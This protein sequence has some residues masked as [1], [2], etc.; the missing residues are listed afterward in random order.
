MVRFSV[1]SRT[2]FSGGTI[3]VEDSDG[4]QVDPGNVSNQDNVSFGKELVA[5][6]GTAEALNNGTSL[7]VPDNFG[8]LIQGNVSSSSGKVYVGHS[9]VTSADGYTLGDGDT[10]SLKVTDVSTIFVDADTADD[11]GQR[12]D[13]PEDDGK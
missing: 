13:R 4:T 8:V 6:A 9:Q 12:S 5:S 10:V 3:G 1:F 2:T 11:Q 7:S